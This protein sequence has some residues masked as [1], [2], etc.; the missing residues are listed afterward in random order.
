MSFLHT[1]RVGFFD[2]SGEQVQHRDLGIEECVELLQR[3]L[4]VMP[5]ELAVKP[6]PRPHPKPG[7]GIVL[8]SAGG[9]PVVLKHG[10]LICPYFSNEYIPGSIAFA[11]FVCREVGCSIY[12]DDEGRTLSLEEFVPKRSLGATLREL[13][14]DLP[15]DGPAGGE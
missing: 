10:V 2:V 13:N 3:F 6:E 5:P 8:A 11:V 9:F 12:S 1:V 7:R 14:S 15:E 4:D